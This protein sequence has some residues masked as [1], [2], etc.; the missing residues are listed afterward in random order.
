[1]CSEDTPWQRIASRQNGAPVDSARSIRPYGGWVCVSGLTLSP[2]SGEM[3]NGVRQKGSSGLHQAETVQAPIPAS[4]YFPQRGKQCCLLRGTSPGGGSNVAR[5]A[6]LPPEGEAMLPA[7][8]YFPRRGSNVARFAVL[9][10]EG[11][12]CC[13]LRGTS[14][15]GEAML[16]ASRYFPRRGKHAAARDRV[17][18][19]FGCRENGLAMDSSGIN[20]PYGVIS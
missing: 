12:Q 11:K 18:G 8:R 3:S 5:F 2:P 1:L 6:V 19:Y 14:P 16:P 7:S 20:R 15:G 10:P 13:P 9:P 4:R 17:A